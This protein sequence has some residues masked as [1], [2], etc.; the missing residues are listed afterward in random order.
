[1]DDRRFDNTS[2]RVKRLVLDFEKHPDAY[3][4]LDDFLDIIDFYAAADYPQSYVNNSKL[5][6]ALRIAEEIYPDKP[7]FKDE[8]SIL[9]NLQGQKI[10][11]P[12]AG[13]LYIRNGKISINN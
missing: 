9:Y 12:E 5:S 7:T 10:S 2:K 1:M 4:D 6:Q 8:Q 13:R 11:R 3:R